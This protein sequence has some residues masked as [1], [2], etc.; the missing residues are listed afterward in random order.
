M[1]GNGGKLE[2]EDQICRCWKTENASE[3]VEA[4]LTIRVIGGVVWQPMHKLP[5]LYSYIKVI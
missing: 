2:Q 3:Y 4:Q 1:C 5:K